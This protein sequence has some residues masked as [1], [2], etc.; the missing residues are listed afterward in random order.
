MSFISAGIVLVRDS[1]SSIIDGFQVGSIWKMSLR[2]APK[3]VIVVRNFVVATIS[4]AGA[5]S[6]GIIF[7]H[8]KS[9]IGIRRLDQIS[10][11]IV[12]VKRASI[13]RI[14]DFRCLA[15]AVIFDLYERS[16][17]IGCLGEPIVSI[18]LVGRLHILFAGIGKRS[19]DFCRFFVAGRIISVAGRNPIGIRTLCSVPASVKN[20]AGNLHV[21]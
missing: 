10:L 13:Q 15:Q 5:A 16:V 7:R 4:K 8:L 18:V 1:S 20:G 14:D 6:F 19:L 17:G 21:V 2:D 3:F 11:S 9:L 12:L